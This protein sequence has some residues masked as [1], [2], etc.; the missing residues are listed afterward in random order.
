MKNL[1]RVEIYMSK[2]GKY[3]WSLLHRNGYILADS[4]QGY[5]RKNGALNAVKSVFGDL[6]PIKDLTVDKRLS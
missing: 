5:A 1:K 6:Y 4:G 3:R 2:D